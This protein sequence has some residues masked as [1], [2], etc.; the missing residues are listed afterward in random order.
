MRRLR[1]CMLLGGLGLAGCADSPTTPDGAGPGTGSSG[2]ES[3]AFQLTIDLRSGAIDVG[4]P[5]AA[6]TAAAA[7]SLRPSLSLIGSDGLRMT[8][9]G[10]AFTAIPNNPKMKRCTFRLELENKLGTTDLVTPTAFPRPPAGTNGILVFPLSAS[11][12]GGLSTTATPS[13]DWDRPPINFFNDTGVC[14]SGG[15]SD[16]Y[17]YEVFTS[18]MYARSEE[19]RT[20][21]FD[22]PMDATSVTA[23]VVVAADLRDNPRR[24]GPFSYVEEACGVVNT[25][26][27]IAPATEGLFIGARLVGEEIVVSRSFYTWVNAMPRVPVR[28]H[29][30]KLRFYNGRPDLDGEPYVEYLPY[31]TTLDQ[32]DYG[33]ASIVSGHEMRLGEDW[34]LGRLSV[35]FEADVREEIQAAADAGASTFQFRIRAKNEGD[36]FNAFY[37]LRH[38]LG[39]TL[40]VTYSLE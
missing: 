10:C 2:L 20:V 34:S 35:E 3:H 32:S 36:T 26:G 29:E 24:G 5:A 14:S 25:A 6:T 7:G 9:G 30:A 37:G 38:P 21:G 13:P 31:G 39:P 1:H 22:V 19:V 15:K 17:R 11:A 16:C 33:L 4:G 12:R 40:E 27:E 23:Y 18:P 8:A 28:V